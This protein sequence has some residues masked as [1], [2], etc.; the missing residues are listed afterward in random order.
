MSVGATFVILFSI[1]TG[2]A[3]FVRHLRIPY[4]VAL[5]V[6]GLALGAFHLVEAPLVGTGCQ[7]W[8]I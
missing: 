5:V 4:T 1:A 8:A 2:V 7:V 3:I 6:V